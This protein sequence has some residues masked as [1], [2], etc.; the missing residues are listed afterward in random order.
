M[1]A[2]E[3]KLKVCYD[4]EIPNSTIRSS[5]IPVTNQCPTKDE[6]RIELKLLDSIIKENIG[7]FVV[8]ENNCFKD[9]VKQ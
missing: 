5:Y 9:V 7:M 3:K 6:T 2:K 1:K 4:G 8:T